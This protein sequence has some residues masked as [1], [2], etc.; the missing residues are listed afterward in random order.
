MNN[1]KLNV[2]LLVGGTSPERQV[3]KASSKSIYKALT[4]LGYNVKVF[5]P[6]LGVNQLTNIDDYFDDKEI[7]DLKN[8]NYIKLV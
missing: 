1:D 5:D 7:G 8:E 3:S 2:A 4:E 6:G